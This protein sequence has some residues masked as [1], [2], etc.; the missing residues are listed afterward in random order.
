M[1][2]GTPD[3]RGQCITGMGGDWP[4]AVDCEGTINAGLE[5]NRL[6]SGRSLS[7]CSQGLPQGYSPSERMY[8]VAL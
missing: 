2:S 7:I 4:A 3:S 6:G 1:G 5:S 8:S